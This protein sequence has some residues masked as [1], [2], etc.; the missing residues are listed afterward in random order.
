[1]CYNFEGKYDANLLWWAVLMTSQTIN[2]PEFPA[3]L[4]NRQ[5]LAWGI[6]LVAF[7]CFCVLGT[8]LVMGVH[9]FVF[10]ST[11]LIQAELQV[12]RGTAIFIGS[13][14]FERA[15]QNTRDLEANGIVTTDA[16][17][18]AMISFRD[19]Y[20][21]GMVIASLTV[22]NGASVTTRQFIRPRFDVSAESYWI[23]LI[24][25]EGEFDLA[26]LPSVTRPLVV[27]VDTSSGASARFSSEG[28]YELNITESQMEIVNYD[29]DALV[30]A[31]ERR[32]Y[33]IPPGQRAILQL[34]ESRTLTYAP[35]YANLL[36]NSGL[37]LTNVI[38]FNALSEQVLPLV[39]RCNNWQ[40]SGPTGQYGVTME[41]GRSSLR[42]FRGDG[43]ESHGE[44]V[45]VQ[46]YST[47]Q[48]L[49]VSMF[50][51]LS[52]R[53]TFKIAS[54][55]LSACGIVGSECPL[56][57]RIDYYPLEGD[58]IQ[59]WYH[60][61]Y[62]Y[63]NPNLDFLKKCDSCAE[64]HEVINAGRWYT[65]DSGNFIASL[66]P[67]QRPR[68]ILNMRLYASGHE[69]EVFVSDIGLFVDQAAIPLP[70]IETPSTG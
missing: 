46:G 49:D 44:T 66:P 57:L 7:S 35:A 14:L 6:M 24:N 52:V 10:Q 5:N 67:A 9:Y 68:A 55:S 38:D 42:L 11:V 30:V 3:T 39:W 23:H 22:E 25:V 32:S 54:H 48:G 16:Q 1:M 2:S 12:S 69:Y 37:S 60:G 17:S 58:T 43:A 40:D 53:T 19:P 4:Q 63:Q 33:P 26:V 29:G 36:G 65:Y 51:Y 61:F 20:Q 15:V 13:D 64:N 21:E 59:T 27:T 18:Q 45:C 47:A 34:D 70:N 41:D 31:S 62:A 8:L 28:R 50:T 56:M